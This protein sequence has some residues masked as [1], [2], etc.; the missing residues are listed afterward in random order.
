MRRPKNNLKTHLEW[1]K[2]SGSCIPDPLLCKLAAMPT[3]SPH[4]GPVQ[5]ADTPARPPRSGGGDDRIVTPMVATAPVDGTPMTID[6]TSDGNRPGDKVFDTPAPPQRKRANVDS[7]LIADISSSIPGDSPPPKT[8]KQHLLLTD[9]IFSSDDEDFSSIEPK[10]TPGSE[11]PTQDQTLDRGPYQDRMLDHPPELDKNKNPDQKTESERNPD[12][13]LG[14]TAEINVT[15]TLPSPIGEVNDSMRDFPPPPST[16]EASSAERNG[17]PIDPGSSPA[18][19]TM[20]LISL[21]RKLLC[22]ALSKKVGVLETLLKESGVST[23]KYSFQLQEL[24]REIARSNRRI[25][26]YEAQQEEQEEKGDAFVTKTPQAKP[27]EMDRAQDVISLDSDDFSDFQGVEDGD[28]MSDS[29][30]V[31]STKDDAMNDDDSMDGDVLDEAAI[32]QL[33]EQRNRERMMDIEDIDDDDDIEELSSTPLSYSLNYQN[34]T[35]VNS[36]PQGITGPVSDHHALTAFGTER[37]PWDDEVMRVLRSKFQLSSF[38]KHQKE[39]IN[40]TLSGKDVLVLM[41]TGGGKSLCYQLPA[42]VKSGKTKGVTIVISPLISLMQDQ[43]EA[44]QNKGVNAIV[45]NSKTS[46]SDRTTK[47]NLLANDGVDLLY[48]SPEMLNTSKRMKDKLFLLYRDGKIARIVIDEAHCVSSWGHDFR[49]D[50]KELERLKDTYPQTPIMA[51]TATANK[52]VRLD[53]ARCLRDDSVFLHQTFN[54]P[55][56]FYEVRQKK[57]QE[58]TMTQIKEIMTVRYPRKSGIIYCH[59]RRSCEDTANELRTL[60][61]NVAFYHAGMDPEHRDQIQ[62]LWQKGRI[63]TLCATVAFGMG[64]DKPD[65][66]YV[67]HLTVPHTVEGYYQETGRAGRDGN[68]SECILFYSY[69]DASMLRRLISRDDSATPEHRDHLVEL[70][71]RM[72]QYCEDHVVCRRTQ[73]LAYFEEVFDK[74]QCNKTCDNCRF[75]KG[76]DWKQQEVTEQAKHAVALVGALQGSTVPLGY[77]IDVY[78]GSNKVAILRAGHEKL[79]QHGYGKDQAPN[80]T[81]RLFHGLIAQNFL[82]EYQT[83]KGR[84]A[85]SYLKKGPKAALLLRGQ[86]RV[87]ISMPKEMDT[88]TANKRQKTSKS[89]S[90][91]AMIN[92]DFEDTAFDDELSSPYFSRHSSASTSTR[93][94]RSNGYNGSSSRRPATG[95]RK[96]G[97]ATRPSQGSRFGAMPLI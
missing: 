56:L 7:E 73:I 71:N 42:L 15:G 30:V 21:H 34:L 77:V 54:R 50:Y 61:L 68:P 82:E 36:S 64:I 14:Q 13:H 62:E 41:P 49:T 48:V 2:S 3:A 23:A 4:N 60:G 35:Q 43:V 52:P 12:Q 29:A 18:S 58:D 31:E 96:R 55:N 39:A 51:L 74:S 20:E 84:F 72:V 81:Q 1:L 9:D 91:A 78:R 65:V 53:I 69:K 16:E 76:R 47:F 85:F 83:Y 75:N 19:V 33:M 59:S 27:S 40:A 93:R 5:V 90:R 26:L 37:F 88:T 22:E 80:F 44:L 79:P 86:S 92:D 63:S 45:I 95:K 67:V 89:T 6:L 94:N 8:T 38:R 11:D 24:E 57:S 28:D 70:F 25:T 97:S 17:T 46:A 87:V 66:R 32:D 10:I